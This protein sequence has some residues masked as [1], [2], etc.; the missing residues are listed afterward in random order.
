MNVFLQYIL[1]SGN[2][3]RQYWTETLVTSKD[4]TGQKLS[5]AGLDFRVDHTHNIHVCFCT[6]GS[7]VIN[8]Y[9]YAFKCG[10]CQFW[11]YI[12]HPLKIVL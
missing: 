7:L 11:N 10:L 2:K 5:G 8:V 3:Q 4:S 12:F 1:E 6:V 9:M